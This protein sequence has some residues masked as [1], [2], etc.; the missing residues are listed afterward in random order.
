M[1]YLIGEQIQLGV[2]SETTRG[3]AVSPAIW[4]PA[5]VPETIVAVVD[6]ATIRETRGSGISSQGTEVMQVR[7]EGDVEFNVRS[8]GIGYFLKSLLGTDTPVTAL[9]A[10]THVFTRQVSGPQNPSL[11]L[12]VVQPGQQH[13]EYPLTIVKTLELNVPID[14]LVN[15][16]VGFMSKV[17]NTHANYTAAFTETNDVIFRPQDVT[18]KFASTTAGLAAASA[19]C[20]QDLKLKIDNNAHPSLCVGQLNPAD[21]FSVVTEISG[22]MKTNYEGA[23]VYYNTFKSSAYQA[24]SIAMERDDLPVI[25]T[26]AKFHKV[27]FIF[28]RV[29]FVGYKPDRPIDDIVT[30]G[31]DFMAHFDF[32]TSSAITVNVQNAQATY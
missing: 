1:A 25:G 4:I 7:A 23:T 22:S 27:E 26:S 24:M 17:E 5:R 15:A 21:I 2:A 6:T 16:K 28:P 11:S 14:D 13:Y 19:I 30:E 32:S 12:A 18:V 8:N 10:T 3:T 9:G 29:S 20:L 31:I